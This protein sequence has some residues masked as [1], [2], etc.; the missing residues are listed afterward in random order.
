[1]TTPQTR[2][3]ARLLGATALASALAFGAIAAAGGEAGAATLPQAHTAQT[4][5]P[6]WARPNAAHPI[7]FTA[8]TVTEN[9]DGSYTVSWTA[10]GL[11]HVTVYAGSTETR[12]DYRHAVARGGASGSV[13]IAASAIPAAGASK[14]RQWFR[15]V[16]SRGEG[17]TLAD[18]SLH[19]A[20]APN[21]RDA[22][23]YR[24]ADGSWV[25]MGVV[26]RSGDISKLSA[27]DLAELQR[28]GIHTIYDLRTDAEVAAAPDQVPAGATDTQENI[29]GAAS[30]SGFSPT[31][32]AA[33]TEEMI[34]AEV[35]MVDASTAQSGYHNVLTGIADRKD[36]AVVYHCTAGKD[37]TGWASAV[38][39]TALGVP[40]ATVEADYL[41]SNT[42]NAASNAAELA[43][44]PP[45]YQA[46]YQPLLAVEPAYL[47]SG[48]NTVTAQYGTFDNYLSKGLGLD[49]KTLR[50][51]RAEL[52]VG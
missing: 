27:A 26:Y 1:M 9:A 14:D 16:P 51:L 15:L 43:S 31:S 45:A 12:I 4:A 47:A 18:R 33:A 40:Q 10:T 34:Q 23:G 2:R 28:L 21:F 3:T 30:T 22:G 46:I 37:R 8:A 48:F 20:S 35:I 38:L 44:L 42:Y 36:Q 6:A 13:T 5:L 17:L 39:L 32:P 29:L 11:S 50:K 24:T 7:P 19:L 25:K 49:A 41:A 52:L